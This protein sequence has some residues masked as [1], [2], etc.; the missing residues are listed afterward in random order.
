LILLS[1]GFGVAYR[2]RRRRNTELFMEQPIENPLAA[3]IEE[4][5]NENS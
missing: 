2:I 1:L 4:R 5:L 3:I